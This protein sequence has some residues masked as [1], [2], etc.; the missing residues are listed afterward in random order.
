[1]IKHSFQELINLQKD[2]DL[3]LTQLSLKIKTNDRIHQSFKL[4][5]MAERDRKDDQK[6]KD[7]MKNELRR[8]KFYFSLLDIAELREI[9]KY[10]S[11]LNNKILK[12][13]IKKYIKGNILPSEETINNNEAKNIGF[14]LSLTSKFISDGYQADL[15][16]NNPDILV[17]VDKNR[18]LIECKRVFSESGIESAVEDGKNQLNRTLKNENDFG[19]IAISFSRIKTA[20]DMMVVCSDENDAR[21]Q[22]DALFL[23]FIEKNQRF[24]RR[25]NNKQIIAVLLHFSSLIG[26]DNELPLSTSNFIV[27][28]NIY[29]NDPNFIKLAYDLKGLKPY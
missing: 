11:Q 17:N 10:S 19:I 18:Y 7:F 22:M 8:K 4:I 26:F 23:S 6:A 2:F 21:Q 14:E 3:L 28:N 12:E 1:M 5:E 9:L 24:W 25:I 15:C 27:L 16:K 20:S 13:K 29:D